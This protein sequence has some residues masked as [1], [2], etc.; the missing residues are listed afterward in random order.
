MIIRKDKK[1]RIRGRR[2]AE[3]DEKEEQSNRRYFL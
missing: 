2:P 1:E 3:E